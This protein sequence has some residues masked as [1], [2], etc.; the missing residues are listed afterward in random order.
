M[1]RTKTA[2]QRTSRQYKGLLRGDALQ[3]VTSSDGTT[4][5][6]FLKEKVG[7]LI[8]SGRFSGLVASGIAAVRLARHP[9]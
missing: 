7:W 6:Y 2:R 5:G 1:R 9:R 4:I 8:P 3:N